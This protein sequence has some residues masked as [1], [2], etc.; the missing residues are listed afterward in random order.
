[1]PSVSGVEVENTGGGTLVVGSVQITGTN[2]SAFTATLGGTC[3]TGVV[4]SSACF[5][6]VTLNATTAGSYSAN[7]II[8]DN[9]VGSPHTVTMSGTAAAQVNVSPTA[10]EYGGWLLGTQSADREMTVQN[11]TGGN[12]TLTGIVTGGAD[13]GDFLT[14]LNP[15]NAGVQTC[16]TNLVLLP[17][18]GRT[19]TITFT[20]SGATSGSQVVNLMGAGETGVTLYQTSLTG[21]TEYVGAT[22][23]GT[24]IDEIFNGTASPIVVTG[25]T[26]SGATPQ[27]FHLEL[28]NSCSINGTI[29]ANSTC[30]LDSYD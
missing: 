10:I 2:A 21:L 5:I 22:Q 20:W 9:A 8:N 23:Q 13:P 26:L 25:I 18:D 4:P 28:D 7:L 17:G 3:T 19:A 12:I 27:D 24:D 14:D 1:V 30:Y 11:A 15:P 16:S 6:S 29:P